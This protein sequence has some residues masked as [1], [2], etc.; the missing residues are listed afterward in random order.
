MHLVLVNRLFKLVQE[1]SVIR[2]TNR[3]DM[4]I[5]VYWD[6][7]QQTNKQTNQP[8]RI[9]FSTQKSKITLLIHDLK[10]WPSNGHQSWE[11]ENRKLM[12]MR[13]FL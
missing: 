6:V 2:W 12:K 4:T 9:E 10:F 1:K 11:H 8:K 7:K 3:L 13:D 5:A